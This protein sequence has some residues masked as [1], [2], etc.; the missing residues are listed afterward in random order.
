M[1]PGK[2]QNMQNRVTDLDDIEK[3]VLRITIFGFHD[4]GEFPTAKNLALELRDTINY[5]GSVL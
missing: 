5:I 4:S 3:D 2:K 1:S